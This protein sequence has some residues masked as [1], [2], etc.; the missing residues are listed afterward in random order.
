MQRC[1]AILPHHVVTKVDERESNELHDIQ[2]LHVA[3]PV[4]VPP[5]PG[6]SVPMAMRMFPRKRVLPFSIS[7]YWMAEQTAPPKRKMKA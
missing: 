5:M 7:E 6:R 2:D 4:K 3:E 1:G